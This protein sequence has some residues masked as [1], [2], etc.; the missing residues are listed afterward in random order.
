MTSLLTA[1]IEFN[2]KIMKALCES[3][4]D[5]DDDDECL[6]SGEKL[7]GDHIKL[8]CKHTF[9]YDFIFNEIKQQKKYNDKEISKVKPWELKCPYCRNIQQGVL[10]WNK[11]Y[12]KVNKVNW[13]PKYT[14]YGQLKHS[15]TAILKSGKRKGEMCGVSSWD[16]LCKR[17]AKK[18]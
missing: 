17:H 8:K 16:T 12:P 11:N 13:P 1:T 5:D 7:T 14:H 4:S 18:K 10:P 3:D 9:N 2:E 15:C 6:I